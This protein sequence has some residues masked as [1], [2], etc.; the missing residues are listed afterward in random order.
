[1]EKWTVFGCFPRPALRATPSWR[2]TAQPRM[3]NF[4]KSF[5]GRANVYNAEG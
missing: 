4:S 5:L 1:M 3:L 2:G